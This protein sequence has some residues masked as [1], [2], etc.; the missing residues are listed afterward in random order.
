MHHQ[1]AR[2]MIH[3]ST[4]EGIWDREHARCERDA[5]VFSRAETPEQIR[6][7]ETFESLRRK[8]LLWC[9]SLRETWYQ[10]IHLKSKLVFVRC[11]Y[12]CFSEHKRYSAR[13]TG[14]MRVYLKKRWKKS[15]K[16]VD[17]SFG[18]L[19][20]SFQFTFAFSPVPL[21]ERCFL[22]PFSPPP[23][24]DFRRPRSLI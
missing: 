2:P 6:A 8:Y 13:R 14:G 12:F 24:F 23:L 19:P 18:T 7:S 11:I 17:R 16:Q 5:P 9:G 10:F 20:G 4:V 15:R 22:L 21:R 3:L 1:H